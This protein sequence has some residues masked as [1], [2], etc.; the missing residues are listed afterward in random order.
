MDVIQNCLVAATQTDESSPTVI[1]LNEKRQMA[2]D[3][4]EQERQ[5]RKKRRIDTMYD[6]TDLVLIEN[7]NQA[8]GEW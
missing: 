6:E 7:Y 5:R 4:I 2:I 8:I 1:P 3:N